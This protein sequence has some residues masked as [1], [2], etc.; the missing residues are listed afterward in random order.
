V[1]LIDKKDIPA[2]ARL[3]LRWRRG[4]MLGTFI[5]DY[6]LLIPLSEHDVR[7]TDNNVEDGMLR[8]V[9]G[10]TTM[11]GPSW[12]GVII[13]DKGEQFIDTPK[14]DG[15]HAH[16]DTAHLGYLPVWATFEDKAMLSIN[17]CKI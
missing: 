16:F 8:F 13:E 3:E 11:R 9:L 7:W 15:M 4:D 17:A 2:G 12:S 6:L 1:A 5:C 14:R 10:E